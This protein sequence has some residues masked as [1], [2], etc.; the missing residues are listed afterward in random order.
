[1]QFLAP[2]STG[3]VWTYG[4]EQIDDYDK[5]AIDAKT[6]NPRVIISKLPVPDEILKYSE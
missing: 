3:K 1:M 6:S 2:F 5:L 4:K